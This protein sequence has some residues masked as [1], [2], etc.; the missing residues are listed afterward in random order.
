[1]TPERRAAEMAWYGDRDPHEVDQEY[2]EYDG[3]SCKLCG[4]ERVMIGGATGKR[5]CEKCGSYQEDVQ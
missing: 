5:I 3:T 2:G 4:R 1:M